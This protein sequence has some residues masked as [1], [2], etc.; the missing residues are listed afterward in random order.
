MTLLLIN[1][2]YFKFINTATIVVTANPI[3]IGFKFLFASSI[4]LTPHIAAAEINPQGTKHPP[5]VHIP[6]I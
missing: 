2:C 6:A 4:G 1:I 3:N 5:P